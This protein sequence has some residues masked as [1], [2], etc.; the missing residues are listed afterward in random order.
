MNIGQGVDRG[1][2]RPAMWTLP[3]EVLY[4]S[5]AKRL[6][7]G[8]T[9][10]MPPGGWLAKCSGTLEK[11]VRHSGTLSALDGPA[12]LFMCHRSAP[13]AMAMVMPSPSLYGEPEV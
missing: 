8:P 10:I 11:V 6:P 9:T 13:T 12:K 1:V 5:S 4:F 7:F 3:C 2:Q